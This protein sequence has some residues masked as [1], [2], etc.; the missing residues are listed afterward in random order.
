MQAAPAEANVNLTGV[1]AMRIVRV[2]IFIFL[3]A[4]LAFIGTTPSR[5]FAG[6]KTRALS[7]HHRTHRAAQKQAERP[8]KIRVKS[9]QQQ[10]GVNPP[11][12]LVPF[13]TDDKQGLDGGGPPY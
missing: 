12:L 1:P 3:A 4:A 8:R 5:M 9:V 13:F 10:Q 11:L 6:R 2:S 7:A